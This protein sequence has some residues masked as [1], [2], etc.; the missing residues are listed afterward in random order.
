MA[1][2]PGA[3]PASY[4]RSMVAP[5][6]P[7]RRVFLADLG[8]A[9]FAVAIL[10]VAGCAAATPATPDRPAGASAAPDAAG[11]TPPASTAPGGGTPSGADGSQGATSWHRVA[12]INGEI[13]QYHFELVCVAEHWPADGWKLGL[14][15]D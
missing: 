13:E 11:A 3:D 8:R 7:T 1:R 15:V 6:T 4:H 10:G 12:C 9:G 5:Y 2:D 14:D